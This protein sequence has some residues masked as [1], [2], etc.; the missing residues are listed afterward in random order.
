MTQAPPS[1]FARLWRWGVL[2][3]IFGAVLLYVAQ[4]IAPWFPGSPS[5]LVTGTILGFYLGY[6]ARTLRALLIGLNGGALCGLGLDRYSTLLEKAS[7]KAATWDLRDYLIYSGHPSDYL[8][9]L[10]KLLL[11]DYSIALSAFFLL[12]GL[13]SG[14]FRCGREMLVQGCIRG[15]I[16]GVVCWVG[17]RALSWPD[18]NLYFRQFEFLLAMIQSLALVPLLLF[19]PLLKPPVDESSQPAPAA[20]QEE[21][22]G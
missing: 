9:E 15:I 5:G 12:M 22:H 17:F 18:R 21:D 16:A 8:V 4:K 1:I 20:H 6:L 10:L 11:F 3:I 7:S 2:P 19:S 14:L 13:L